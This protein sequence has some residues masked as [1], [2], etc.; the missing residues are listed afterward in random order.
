MP[1]IIVAENGNIVARN[2]NKV[3]GNGD[4]VAWCGQA[5]TI[6]TQ[7]KG[8]NVGADANWV[9]LPIAPDI[10][11]INYTVLRTLLDILFI[12][13]WEKYAVFMQVVETL[14]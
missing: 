1:K 3:T 10:S 8:S 5:I 2:G 12:F 7:T 14:W 9:T 11:F 6:R 4:F 13:L